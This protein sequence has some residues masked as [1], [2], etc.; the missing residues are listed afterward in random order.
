[1]DT[2]LPV[3]MPFTSPHAVLIEELRA[4]IF[5]KR[6]IA[7]ARRRES[8]SL[9]LQEKRRKGLVQRFHGLRQGPEQGTAW[10]TVAD[11]E[12]HFREG[13]FL[14]LHTGPPLTDAWAREV[15][16]KEERE[17]RW[18]LRFRNPRDIPVQGDNLLFYAEQDG[19]DLTPRYLQALDE[20]A[21]G[22]GAG[23]IILQLLAGELSLHLDSLN[24]KYACDLALAEG[25]NPRQA[26]AVGLAYAV[27]YVACFETTRS[28]VP[29]PGTL[30]LFLLGMGAL[31]LMRSRRGAGAV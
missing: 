18:L 25:L 4:F 8:W 9:D 12:S 16:F 31:G 7:L 10:A 1:M 17:K 15:L 3:P 19:I 29:L 5:E 24:N 21:V 23:S 13:D 2:R 27:N 30:P 20:V 11:G 26:A 6:D 14:C 28:A 22:D